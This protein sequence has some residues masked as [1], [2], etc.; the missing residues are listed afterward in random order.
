M[1]RIL[2]VTNQVNPILRTGRPRIFDVEQFPKPLEIDNPSNPSSWY[3]GITKTLSWAQRWA[4]KIQSKLTGAILGS[5]ENPS[6]LRQAL[7]QASAVIGKM[8]GLFDYA[9]EMFQQ[10]KKAEEKTQ[11]LA[12]PAEIAT[13]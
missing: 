12:Y 7:F 10:N 9:I 4:A 6:I 3:E 5:N 11:K 13:A 2:P 1:P 8:Y